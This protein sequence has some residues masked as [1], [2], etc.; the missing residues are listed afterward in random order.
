MNASERIKLIVLFL[1]MVALAL[2]CLSA[3]AESKYNFKYEVT[4]DRIV[5]SCVDD[6]NPIMR[7]IP[8]PKGGYY[9][10]VVCEGRK[11]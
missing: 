10:V 1:L 3:N 7:T 11:F 2:I 4:N 5:V 9:A 6:Q 8:R